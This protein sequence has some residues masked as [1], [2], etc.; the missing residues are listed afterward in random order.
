MPSFLKFGGIGVPPVLKLDMI[1]VF[2]SLQIEGLEYAPNF[3]NF[4]NCIK[5]KIKEAFPLS[6]FCTFKFK[7]QQNTNCFNTL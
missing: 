1:G 2:Q 7:M 4:D 6:K 5:V 3:P